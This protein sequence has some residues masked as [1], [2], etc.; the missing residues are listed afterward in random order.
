MENIIFYFTGTGNSLAVARGIANKIENVKLM[1][2]AD[3]IKEENID[4]SLY[5]RIGFVIPVYYQR[6]PDIVKRFIEKLNF[7]RSQYIF[8]VITL[9]GHYGAIFSE[10]EYDIS[11]RGGKLNS[12]FIVF[13]PGNYIAHYNAS[14]QI[15]QKIF[16]RWK[17]RDVNRIAVNVREKKSLFERKFAWISGPAGVLEVIQKYL[18]PVDTIIS[19][20]GERAKEFN[21]SN[22]CT[23]CTLCEKICPVDNI[24]IKN[25]EPNWGKLC[26]QCMACI[27]WCPVEAIQ[28]GNK[29]EKRKRY[30]N[31]EIKI[32][33]MISNSIINH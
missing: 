4:L 9:A 21:V 6:V 31:P 8:S 3:A 30:H 32:A 13:M 7:T 5:E 19:S 23:G 22:K 28:Y 18:E 10:L 1:S 12:G 2:I 29:T 17:D 14:P 15:V 33:D 24:K 11:L 16:F 20:F 26:E 25:K 27:Q